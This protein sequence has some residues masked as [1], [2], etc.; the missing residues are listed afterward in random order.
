MT[1][2]ILINPP[3]S[4]VEDDRLEPQLGLLYIAAV[5]REKGI[6]VQIYEM[7]GCKTEEQ[8][9]RKIKKIPAGE[10]YG[11]TTYCTNYLYV[12]SCID[13]IH[14]K[15]DKSFIVLGG[16]NP[17]ALPE[18]T[19]RDSKCDCVI[20]GEGEDAFLHVVKAV[21]NNSDFPP[22]I[23]GTVRHD[24][25]T[26][27]IPAWDL[28]DMES[29][30]R[31]LEGERVI[32]II[33]SRGCKYNCI[34]CNSVVMGGGNKVRYRSA[35][36][37]IKEINFLKTKGFLKF[38]FNDD[39]FTGN[40][41]IS[42]LL[43]SIKKLNIIYRIFARIEDLNENNCRLLAESGCRHISIGLESL[44]PDNLNILGKHTQCGIEEKHLQNTK[45]YRMVTRA[46]FMVGL[47]YDTDEAIQKYFENA[48]KLAFDEFSIYPLI[49]YPGTQIW[50]KPKKFGYEIID[51]DFTQYIQI[52][53]DGKTC[54]VLKH[55]NFSHC[56]VERWFK[57]ATKILEAGGKKHT[58][59]SEVAK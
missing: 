50:N 31:T 59:E 29:Y 2:V 19:L 10:I 32:S 53:K 46:Y 51:K 22:I 56:D 24:I 52:G 17:T 45:K 4:C 12:K 16:P 40:P 8:I 47:P 43:Y 1:K 30:T 35:N 57:I 37:L 41:D 39:N 58:K 26:Y 23:R 15:M 36:N 3:S 48:S 11:F 55:K 44:N 14:S 33:S 20:T 42:E 34:H 28:I 25:D 5:L 9:D 21:L 13:Y 54:F 27:P 6:P 7:T 38:R 18:L 49:P